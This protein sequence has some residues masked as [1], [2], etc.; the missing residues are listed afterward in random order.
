[1]IWMLE[2]Q[3]INLTIFIFILEL[4][5][6]VS[7]TLYIIVTNLSHISYYHIIL[8][9]SYSHIIIYYNRI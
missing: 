6:S 1:M 4:K 7:I 5:I 3:T 9:Q 2:L 8:L